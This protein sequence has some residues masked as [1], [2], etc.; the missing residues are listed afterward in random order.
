MSEAIAVVCFDV[1]ET[2]VDERPMW[3]RWADWLGVPRTTFFDE[4]RGVIARREHHR[5]V[6]ENIR[7]GFDFPAARAARVTAGDEPGFRPQDVHADAPACLYV[8]RARGYGIGI[9]GNTPASVERF[10]HEAGFAADFVASSERW[11]VQKP[12]PAFFDKLAEAAGVAPNRIAYVGDRVDNDVI[13]PSAAGMT[14]IWL[15]RGLWVDVQRDWPEA[16]DLPFAIDTLAALPA[17]L[18]EIDDARRS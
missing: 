17:L 4:L 18:T 1:G 14:G 2:L 16:R 7:P 12:S 3:C 6:F 9:S 5:R 10:L 11:G 13:A 8:L 15:R